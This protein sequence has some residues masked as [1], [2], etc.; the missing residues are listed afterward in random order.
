[1]REIQ[2]LTLEQLMEENTRFRQTFLLGN[3]QDLTAMT[4]CT[5]IIAPAGAVCGVDVRGGSPGTRDTD[6]LN[7][8]CN[9]QTVHGIL[10]SG[11]SAFG[12]DAV[13]GLMKLLEEKGIGR[14]VGVTVVPNV[15]SAVLF[16]LK[17][18]DFRIRPD[19]SMGKAAGNAAFLHQPFLSGNYGAGTGATVGKRNGAENAMKGGL[20]S[21]VCRCGRLYAA[22]IFAVNCVGDVIEHGRILAGARKAGSMDFAGSEQLILQSAEAEKDLFSIRSAADRESEGEGNTVIGVILT[23]ADLN[24]AQST[25]LASQGHNAIARTVYPAH[26]IY[27]GD[28]DLPWL[29]EKSAHRRMPSGS[30]Q[31]MLQKRRFWMPYVPRRRGGLISLLQTGWQR[32]PQKLPIHHAEEPVFLNHNSFCQQFSRSI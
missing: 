2:Y 26:S 29:P 20:G 11:G 19:A 24:K 7:P 21:A 8:L 14:D 9:R 13:G 12:L 10:L 23:N 5:A 30:S 1:M 15:C 25:R 6:A 32:I 3:A 27:D 16:D 4:G 22:A 28:T 18:G 31:P 17:C